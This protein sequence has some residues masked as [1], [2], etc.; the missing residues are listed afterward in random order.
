MEQPAKK[1]TYKKYEK[2][3]FLTWALFVLAWIVINNSR[4]SGELVGKESTGFE[5]QDLEG[6]KKNLNDY[7]GQV[8][9]ISF[10][11]TWCG[12]CIQEMPSLVKLYSQL[13]PKGL[14]VL[15]VNVEETTFYK[16]VVEFKERFT[17]SFPMLLDPE[18]VAQN[19]YGVTILPT[20]FIIDKQGKIVLHEE[21]AQNWASPR[22]IS[23]IEGLLKNP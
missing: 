17:I 18:G 23:M 3:F 8:R 15:G 14:V 4:H 6:N 9:V 1:S 21:G 7:K 11:A 19:A 5:L 2:Y 13:G 22:M 10:W 16:K 20:N 12:P